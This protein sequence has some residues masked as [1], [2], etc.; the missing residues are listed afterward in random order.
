MRQMV[1]ELREADYARTSLSV[2]KQNPALCLYKRLG[3][4]IA[5]NGADDTEWLMI[6]DLAN[7]AI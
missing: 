6:K 7:E 5:G 4:R 1:A 2:Q 3:F